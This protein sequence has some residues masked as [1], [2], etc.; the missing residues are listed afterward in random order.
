MQ[1]VTAMP[2]LEETDRSITDYTQPFLIACLNDRWRVVNDPLQFILQVRRRKPTATQDGWEGRSF[3]RQRWALLRCIREYCGEVS[4]EA[5][6]VI[7]QLPEKHPTT[8]RGGKLVPH[9]ICSADR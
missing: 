6:A 7:H 9:S 2:S 4:P 3:C 5:L 1:T 8:T